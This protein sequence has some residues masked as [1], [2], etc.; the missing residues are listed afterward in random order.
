MRKSLYE[1]RSE[2]DVVKEV[3]IRC[4]K[5]IVRMTLWDR[6]CEKDIMRKSW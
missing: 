3:R 5:D 1:R 2:N 4:E 6:L